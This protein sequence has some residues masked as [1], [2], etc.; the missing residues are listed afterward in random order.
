MKLTVQRVSDV[1]A[2]QLETRILEGSL[3]PGDRL[4]PER[5]LAVELGVSRPSLREAIQKLVSQG[6]LTSR[7]GGGTYVTDRLNASFVDPWAHMVEAHPELQEDLLEFRHMLEGK[8]A[9][10]A[11]RR[12]TEADIQ[13]LDA[14]YE[15]LE[16][17]FN[18]GTPEEL[19]AADTAFHQAIAE[20]S[21][22]LIFGHLM[23]SLFR[24][25]EDHIHRNLT[26]LRN[27]THAFD[28]LMEQHRAIW[29]A[30]RQG[31]IATADQAAR[32]HIG[33][34]VSSMAETAKAEERETIARRRLHE[35]AH[36]TG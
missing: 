11:A 5:E 22:N 6:L 9:A 30:I 32:A 7:Q 21:H 24:L 23:A 4:P 34:V 31:D 14:A 27:R 13:R 36:H 10:L 1:I 29:Q 12:A 17:A 19:T 26:H 3:K 2:H 15:K 28:Q 18:H 35:M 16:Q 20:A 8:A 25:L 33:Y